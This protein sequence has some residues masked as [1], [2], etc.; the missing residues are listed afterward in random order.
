MSEYESA[1]RASE[2][3]RHFPI[4]EQLIQAEA[5]QRRLE[6]EISV[7]TSRLNEI[8]DFKRDPGGKINPYVDGLVKRRADLLQRTRPSAPTSSDVRASALESL[9]TNIGPFFTP[10][11]VANL[12]YMSEGISET[13]GIGGTSGSI[14]TAG[15][16]RGGLGFAAGDLNDDGT[17]DPYTEKW[18]IHTWTTSYVFPE[19]PRDG[20]IYYRFSVGT[21]CLVYH[22]PAY[23][24]LIAEFVTVGNAADVDT[25]SPFDPGTSETVGW[26]VWVTLPHPD[27]LFFDSVS[28]PVLGTIAVQAGKT[29]ALGFIYG[30]IVGLASGYAQIPWASFG[31]RL[32]RPKGTTYDGEVFDKIEYRFEPDWWI[33]AVME[34]QAT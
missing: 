11:T 9:V 3:P 4:P 18:W 15:L 30:A 31:T 1:T 32:T 7:V 5:D 28:V 24:G 21:S 33:K 34:R 17:T 8:A 23:S 16:F 12:P 2:S 25:Q 29:A 6:A 19:A 26:P 27:I 14:G 20:T 13:P 10:W 22:A